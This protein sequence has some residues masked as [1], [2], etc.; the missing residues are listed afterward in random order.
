[1]TRNCQKS[2]KTL[3]RDMAAN[4][5]DIPAIDRDIPALDRDIPA[6][7][8]DMA[9]T[10]E[11]LKICLNQQFHS[12]SQW[13][14]RHAQLQSD[15]MCRSLAQAGEFHRLPVQFPCVIVACFLFLSSE[16]VH[17]FPRCFT[18]ILNWKFMAFLAG[19]TKTAWGH[20]WLQICLWRRV[21]AW[22]P[23]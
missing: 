3:D 5:R 15:H 9:C 4:D 7:D 2:S 12:D 22:A 1:M 21:I 14:S 11:K 18:I 20:I 19:R 13:L 10:S 8:R 16:T 23:A 6:I 17:I